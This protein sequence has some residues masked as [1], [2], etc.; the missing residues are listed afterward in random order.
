VIVL[1]GIVPTFA[2]R[3]GAEERL[4]GRTFGD[5][6]VRYRRQTKMIVP[7]LF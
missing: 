6:L 2:W 3:A 7:R 1:L 5:A 4:L